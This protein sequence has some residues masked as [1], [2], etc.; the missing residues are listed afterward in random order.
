MKGM[1]GKFLKKMK[2]IKPIGYLK[3]DRILQVNAAGGYVES[4]LK[5]PLIRKVRTQ[6]FSRTMTNNTAIT[7]TYARRVLYIDKNLRKNMKFKNLMSL[8]FLNS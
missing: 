7:R 5:N 2:S 8:M 3:T 6:L 1:K 4:F